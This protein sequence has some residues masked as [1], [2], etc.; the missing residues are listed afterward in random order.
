MPT[1]V[2]QL[3]EH[4]KNDIADLEARAERAE[5][6]LPHVAEKYQDRLKASIDSTWQHAKELSELLVEIRQDHPGN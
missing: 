6:L 5:K 3:I 2:E 1:A 4:L